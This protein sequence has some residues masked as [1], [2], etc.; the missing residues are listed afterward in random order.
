MFA[1]VFFTL[2]DPET[3]SLLYIN[4]GHEEPII[5]RANEITQRL[6][7]TGPVVGIFPNVE[8]KIRTARLEPNDVLLV[9]TDGVTEAV[10]VANAR[11]T[12]ERLLEF[13]A[14]TPDRS[15]TTIINNIMTDIGAFSAGA[16]QF[17]DITLLAIRRTA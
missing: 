9:F 10:D 12:E 8:F 1:S 15:P 13:L 5:I 16:Q 4:A 7:P 11:Y 14:Q 2:L 6:P 3:G 17:D